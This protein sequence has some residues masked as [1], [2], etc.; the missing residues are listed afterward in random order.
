MTNKLSLPYLV[1]IN[2]NIHNIKEIT[3][4]WFLQQHFFD[5]KIKNIKFLSQDH[6]MLASL[7]H[8]DSDIDKL[9]LLTDYYMWMFAIEEEF[10]ET[11]KKSEKIEYKFKDLISYLE[12]NGTINE[13][14]DKNNKWL[15][16]YIDIIDRMKLSDYL[17]Y[18]IINTILEWIYSEIE[19]NDKW[20]NVIVNDEKYIKNRLESIGTDNVICLVEYGLGIELSKT[21]INNIKIKKIHKT[22]SK[23]I[24]WYSEITSSKVEMSRNENHNLIIIYMKNN[25]ISYE[26]SR[27]ILYNMFENEK[28]NLEICIHDILNEYK[29]NIEINLY[30]HSLQN[31][32]AAYLHWN[33]N[34]IRYSME[35]FG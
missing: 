22:V 10:E 34:S 32:C 7:I 18:R 4:T 33:L 17:R 31:L 5:S 14:I 12:N 24:S 8:N 30:C 9:I 11:M 29:N 6:A 20:G 28:Q 3:Y 26:K 35:L 13:N 16:P 19:K 2:N 27:L 25:N 21:I 1:K 15:N 23:L